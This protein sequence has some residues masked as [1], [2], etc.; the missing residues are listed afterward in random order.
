MIEP[1]LERHAGD[2]HAELGRI[3][4]IRQSLLT[5]WMFLAEDDLALRAMQRLP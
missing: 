3:G 2:R 5:R 4:E 1:M